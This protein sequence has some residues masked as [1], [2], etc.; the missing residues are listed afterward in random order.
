MKC[1]V[2][3]NYQAVASVVRVPAMASLPRVASRSLT[4]EYIGD[5]GAGLHIGSEEALVQLGWP[6]S[7][8]REVAGPAS[9]KVTFQTGNGD[10]PCNRSIGIY[11]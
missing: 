5:T 6:V 9:H 10:V 1:P 3:S 2:G 4:L 7:D 11:F 8:I